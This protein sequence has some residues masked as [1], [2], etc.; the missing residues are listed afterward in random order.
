MAGPI[1]SYDISGEFV[2]A[3]DCF[4]LCPCWVDDEPDEGH[5][6]GLVAWT[7]SG[8]I[9][10]VTIRRRHVVAVTGHGAGRRAAKSVSVLFVD[11]DASPEEFAKLRAAFSGRDDAG[12]GCPTEP[13]VGTL[14][15]LASVTGLLIGP[16]TQVPITVSRGPDGYRICVGEPGAELVEAA[17]AP[18]RFDGRPTALNLDF[19]ALHKELQI[20][21]PAEAQRGSVLNICMPGLPGGYLEVTTRSGMA[22]RFTYRHR[23][24]TASATR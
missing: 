17:G 11:D 1:T 22:G 16:A 7:V 2:E 20:D 13:V 18:L 9:D 24:T 15:D 5:C 6:T 21:G 8:I 3:C 10:D 19:T 4:E 12:P 23:A 14:G